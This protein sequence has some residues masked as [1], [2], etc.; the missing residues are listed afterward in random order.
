MVL[1]L[2][3]KLEDE[4]Q[5]INKNYNYCGLVDTKENLEPSKCFICIYIL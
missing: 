5:F 4:V 3:N 1:Q 2:Y